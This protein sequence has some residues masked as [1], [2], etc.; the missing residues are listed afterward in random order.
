MGPIIA[1]QVMGY[2][3][4][5]VSWCFR[6]AVGGGA[7]IGAVALGII[8]FLL[9]TPEQYYA[10]CR[11]TIWVGAAFGLLAAFSKFGED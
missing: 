3:L 11:V 6:G 9:C 4:I 10:L 8:I 7:V 5:I 2:I 1:L